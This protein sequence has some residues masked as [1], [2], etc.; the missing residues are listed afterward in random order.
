[1]PTVNIR[2]FASL[3]EM[4]GEREITLALPEGATVRELHAC[5]G[6]AYPLVKPFLPSIVCAV[7]EEYVPSTHPLREG[8]LVALIPPVSGGRS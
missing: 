8:D 4:I 1:M 6:E 7:G 3:R 5:I 2:L